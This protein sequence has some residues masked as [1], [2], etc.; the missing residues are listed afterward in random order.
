M[1]AREHSATINGWSSSA[2]GCSAW[3]SRS[4]L[5]R[6]DEAP[7]GVLSQRLNALVSR[8]TCAAVA[9]SIGLPPHVVLGRQAQ[10]DGGTDSD[11]ILG[12]VMEALLGAHFIETG[13]EDTRDLVHRLWSAKFESDAGE[14]KHPKSALQEWAAGKGGRVPRYTLVERSGP[15]HASRF[16]VEVGVEG[17]GSARATAA[18]KQE[19]QSMAAHKFLEGQT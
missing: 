15:D 10:D 17:F 3:L 13:F 14:A 7:E 1:A 19:A 6:Q 11:N 8:R 9:R 18:S 12:D 16:T 4:G 2:T 5:Y